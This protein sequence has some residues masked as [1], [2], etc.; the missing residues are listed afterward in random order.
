MIDTIGEI[1]QTIAENKI[2]DKMYCKNI[3]KINHSQETKILNNFEKAGSSI[4]EF[5]HN[6]DTS[7]NKRKSKIDKGKE[8]KSIKKSDTIERNIT[9]EDINNFLSRVVHQI[10]IKIQKGQMS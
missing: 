10:R 3:A 1:H 7:G 5:A 2:E 8:R 6:E 9:E 4:S